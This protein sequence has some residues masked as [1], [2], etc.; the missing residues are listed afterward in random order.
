VLVEK[1]ARHYWFG[2]RALILQSAC[3]EGPAIDEKK[4]ALF[5]RY[6]SQHDRA[7]HKALADL[8]KLRKEKRQEEIGFESQKQ[9]AELHEAKVRLLHARSQHIETDSDIHQTIDAPIPGNLR[10]PFDVMKQ[11]LSH[12]V[13]Q[14]AS[15]S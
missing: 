13:R 6:Q 14:V 7:F 1:L 4:L 3:F 15:Q 10:I 2:Q 9:K 12:A 5:L 8:L 11:V